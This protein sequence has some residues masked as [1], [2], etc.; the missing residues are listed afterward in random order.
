MAC[1]VFW[2]AI[3]CCF[4]AL[5]RSINAQDV[6]QISIKDKSIKDTE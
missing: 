1:L 3:D 5:F 2:L 6:K 4:T